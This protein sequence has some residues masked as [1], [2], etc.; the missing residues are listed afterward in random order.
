MNNTAIVYLLV[1]DI[2]DGYDM[3]YAME[4]VELANKMA[5]MEAESFGGT[6][7][8]ACA[9]STTRILEG[10]ELAFYLSNYTQAEKVLDKATFEAAMGAA[11]VEAGG[12]IQSALGVATTKL[13]SYWGD[14]EGFAAHYE[15]ENE[16]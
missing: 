13:D 14:A 6:V 1:E 4:S 11:I 5:A 9:G 10:D 7:Y 2:N 12:C 16:E 3:V 8:E 15:E